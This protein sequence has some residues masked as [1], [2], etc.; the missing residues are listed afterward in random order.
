MTAKYIFTSILALL[1]I[2]LCSSC[3]NE[4]PFN[5]AAKP[6]RLIMNAFIN[7]DST[8]NVLLLNLT[9][10]TVISPDQRCTCRK[11]PTNPFPDR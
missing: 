1:L 4:I 5:K 11:P 2:I 8:N 7:A 9:G 3:E 6:P 10:S